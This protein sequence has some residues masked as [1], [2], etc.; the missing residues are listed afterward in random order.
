MEVRPATRDDWQGIRPVWHAV[1]AAGETYCFPPETD[2]AT[3]RELWMQPEPAEVYVATEGDRIIGTALLRPNL[4]GPGDHVAT[5]AFM[6]DPAAGG[7]G[8]G[9]AL[10]EHLLERARARG[11]QA[12]QLN[13]VVRTNTG[14]L[15]LW[16]SLGFNVV[17]TVPRAFRHPQHGPVDL[18][19]MH[20]PL[21]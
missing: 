20:R 16:R 11:Y 21:T 18:H 14:A 7:R 4:A 17:G 5:A 1:V 2:E 19:I 10:A 15:V 9:R 12:M 13:T 3:A 6:V 8:T